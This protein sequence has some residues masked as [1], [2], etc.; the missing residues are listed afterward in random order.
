MDEGVKAKVGSS[1]IRGGVEEDRVDRSICSW[2]AEVSSEETHPTLNKEHKK[3]KINDLDIIIISKL[4]AK[5]KR[6]LYLISR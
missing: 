3:S 6:S 1:I 5:M 4:S 2:S